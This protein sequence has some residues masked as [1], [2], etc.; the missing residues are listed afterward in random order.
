M[1]TNTYIREEEIKNLTIHL[2]KLEKEEQITPKAS[3]VK[4]I[5]KTRTEINKN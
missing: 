5:I 4:E 3:R 1:Y 2:R